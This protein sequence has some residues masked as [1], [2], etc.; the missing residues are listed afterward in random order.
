MKHINL[1]SPA[2]TALRMRAPFGVRGAG[3]LC[4][5]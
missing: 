4:L 5:S 1:A 3:D 2:A